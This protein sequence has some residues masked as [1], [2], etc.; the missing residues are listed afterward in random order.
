MEDYIIINKEDLDQYEIDPYAKDN[1]MFGE[2]EY[3]RLLTDIK[4]F[5]Q[6]QPVIIFEKRIIDGRNRLRA[7]KELGLNL[8]VTVVDTSYADAKRLADSHNEKRRH[9]SKSQFAMR[10][11]F[12]I[13]RSRVDEN[14]A[15]LPKTEW[16]AIK[17][18]SEVA[19]KTVSSRNVS[20][21]IKICEKNP[22]LAKQVFDG[23]L[24]LTN[25]SRQLEEKKEVVDENLTFFKGDEASLNSYKEYTAK[26][27]FTK[28]DL[29]KKLVELEK[30]LEKND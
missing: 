7:I 19:D 2:D 11:A 15:D 20:T 22:E 25:A 6:K 18:A 5:G 14:E 12:K 4:E 30:K 24:E 13:M 29:A 10:A 3:R 17:D 23:E 26:G 28:Q 8:K 1:P 16:I 9:L 27:V 21:A